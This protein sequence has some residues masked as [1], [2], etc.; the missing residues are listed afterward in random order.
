M[1]RPSVQALAGAAL[2]GCWY[3]AATPLERDITHWQPIARRFD[4]DLFVR[5][6]LHCSDEVRAGR[7]VLME[8]AERLQNHV[9]GIRKGAALDTP[10]D[11][12]L[13][14]GFCDFDG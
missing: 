7:V 12:G 2:T 9:L 5:R 4:I 11:E 3:Q 13:D 6:G 8:R 14:F 1:P 10:L